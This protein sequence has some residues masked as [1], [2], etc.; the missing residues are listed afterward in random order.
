MSIVGH[1]LGKFHWKGGISGNLCGA[2][3]NWSYEF[4]PVEGPGICPMVLTFG[5]H[6]AVFADL[7]DNCNVSKHVTPG[8]MTLT[9]TLTVS[10]EH[11]EYLEDNENVE[12]IEQAED[13]LTVVLKSFYLVITEG[14][15]SCPNFGCKPGQVQIPP[16]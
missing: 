14:G 7:Y 9:P 1:P 15:M 11:L 5:Q 8:V 3:V 16:L 13:T 2:Q 6:I 12:T 4:E 10:A